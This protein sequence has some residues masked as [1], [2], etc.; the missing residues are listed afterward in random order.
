MTSTTEMLT[1]CNGKQLRA[2]KKEHVN[3]IDI[4]ADSLMEE[5]S[6]G[7]ILKIRPYRWTRLIS[8]KDVLIKV[9]ASIQEMHRS[10]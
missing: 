3:G 5:Y 8:A 10:L 2:G 7:Q 4:L 6:R 9:I 1:R